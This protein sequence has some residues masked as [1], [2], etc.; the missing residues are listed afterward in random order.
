MYHDKLGGV[1]AMIDGDLSAA[2]SSRSDSRAGQELAEDEHH[3]QALFSDGEVSLGEGGL[4]EV[5]GDSDDLVFF[6]C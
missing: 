1:G 2:Y 4:D 3:Q 5:V 6:V